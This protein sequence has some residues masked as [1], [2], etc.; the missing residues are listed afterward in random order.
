MF[1]AS[2]SLTLPPSEVITPISCQGSHHHHVDTHTH[3]HTLHL[4]YFLTSPSL[5]TSS[6]SWILYLLSPH[7]QINSLHLSFLFLSL[8]YHIFSDL[9][10]SKAVAN[11]SIT[12]WNP[13]VSPANIKCFMTPQP[14][15][16]MEQFRCCKISKYSRVKMDF[17]ENLF[18][19]VCSW[20][21]TRVPE[22]QKRALTHQYTACSSASQVPENQAHA[23]RCYFKLYTIMCCSL[24]WQ[25]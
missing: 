13:V 10:Q 11:T 22:R 12:F 21:G 5:L 18:L 23:P 7:S 9:R 1:V 6:P 19:T 4:S 2:L 20:Q 3:T 25:H 14:S 24:Q 8:T 17:L 15:Q 16:I